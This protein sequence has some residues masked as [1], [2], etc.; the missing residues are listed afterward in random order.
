MATLIEL[1]RREELIRLDPQPG[2]RVMEIRRVYL[3]PRAVEL[4]SRV[5]EMEPKWDTEDASIEQL[6]ALIELFCS[7]EPLA[8]GRQFK[9]LHHRHDGIWEL[10]TADLRLFGWFPQIDCFLMT[11]CD[12]AE[13][14]KKVPLY[15]GYCNEAARC[16]DLLDLDPPKFIPGDDPNVV[17]SNCYFPKT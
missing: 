7:G 16:R 15:D 11:A 17:V 2:P 14:V 13:R 12:Q 9:R 5:P 4:L 1:E 6:D 8:I 3:L 10:K